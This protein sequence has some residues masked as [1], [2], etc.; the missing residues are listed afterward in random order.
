M[1]PKAYNYI[2]LTWIGFYVLGLFVRNEIAKLKINYGSLAERMFQGNKIFIIL[3]VSVAL[4]IVEAYL[5]V[6]VGGPE[7]FACSQ[8]RISSFLMTF[9]IICIF[10]N[11]HIRPNST[12][13]CKFFAIIGDHS[14]GI[15]FVH[16]FIVVL[17]GNKIMRTLPLSLHEMAWCVDTL[18]SVNK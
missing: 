3:L 7:S 12:R 11:C 15:Y 16:Y 14:Y 6:D 18:V 17:A 10:E 1:L 9:L 5:I 13:V 2:P 4:E 8:V